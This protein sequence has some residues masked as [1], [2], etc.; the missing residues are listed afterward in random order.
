MQNVATI[1]ILLV[2]VTALAVIARRVAIPYPTLMVL[3]GLAIGFIPG[4][5]RVELSPDI[6]FLIFLPPL[7]YAAAWNTTWHEFRK[8]LR[9][10]SFLAIGLVLATT[11]AVAAAAHYVVGIPWAPAFVLGA[12]VSPPDAVAATAIAQRL[13]LP[14]DLVSLL[15]GES[16]VNDATGLVAYRFGV[17]AVMTGVFSLPH[18]SLQFVIAATLGI[19]LGLLVGWTVIQIHRRLKDPLI[20]TVITILTP[21]VAYLPAEGIHSL[22]IGVE[23]SGVLAVVAAGLFVGRQSPR[24]FSPNLR[25]QAHAVWDLLIFLLNGVVFILL[26]LQL[27]HVSG[28]LL[29]TESPVPLVWYAAVISLAV[30]LSRVI[31]VFASGWMA[32]NTPIL[33]IVRRKVDWK[34]VTVVAWCGM[35]GVVSLAAAL[36][37]PMTTSSNLPFPN[38]DLIIFLVFAVILVTLVFQSLTLPSLVRWLKITTTGSDEELVRWARLEAAYAALARLEVAAYEPET[39]AEAIVFLKAHYE[40]RIRRDKWNDNAASVEFAIVPPTQTDSLHR[41]LLNTERYMLIKLRDDGSINDEVLH[42]IERD[43]DLQELRLRAAG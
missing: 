43:L 9:P 1:L 38:R 17:L 19:G 28:K 39:P 3:A 42:R 36:A 22:N 34:R 13:F 35:R 37:I 32:E 5:A 7:L 12:I 20:E 16:L 41:E 23:A 25:L 27:P 8:Q 11:V 30:I 4:L 26:G 33:K 10:I 29:L 2:V 40:Q 6:V 18:A 21:Y 24:L 15:E 31:W 14:R